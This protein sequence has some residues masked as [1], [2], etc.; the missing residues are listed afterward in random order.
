M[1]DTEKNQD[2]TLQDIRVII[3]GLRMSGF[4][5]VEPEALDQIKFRIKSLPN[6]EE[7]TGLQDDIASIKRIAKEIG[8]I[9]HLLEVYGNKGPEFKARFESLKGLPPRYKTLEWRKNMSNTNLTRQLV[10]ISANVDY[11]GK[12]VLS[13]K[14]LSLAKKSLDDQLSEQEVKEASTLLSS[15][16]LEKEAKMVE[17]AWW[18]MPKGIGKQVKDV[19]TQIGKGISQ[20]IGQGI[21]KVKDVGQQFGQGVKNIGTQVGQGVGQAVQ[22]VQNIG[23]D[24]KTKW[25]GQYKDK[26]VGEMDNVLTQF[27]QTLDTNVLLSELARLK[28]GWLNVNLNADVNEK[29]IIENLLKH[30]DVLS[31][32]ANTFNKG[33]VTRLKNWSGK[34]RKAIQTIVNG[35]NINNIEK[36][37][38]QQKTTTQPIKQPAKQ[39]IAASQTIRMIRIV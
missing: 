2:L 3:H 7:L 6:P 32:E 26:L 18:S 29:T 23:Q 16:G 25:Q 19:G 15:N 36:A 33:M 34:Q 1:P 9:M 20:S 5:C 30:I 8:E 12:V 22:N 17:A 24:I 38:P 14:L 35:G 37:M 31:Q 4:S 13:E 28:D 39:P 10:R 11:A 21:Q 27:E